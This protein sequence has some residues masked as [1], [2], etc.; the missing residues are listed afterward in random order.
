M[1][2][3][4]DSLIL[5]LI[6]YTLIVPIVRGLSGSG[7][8]DPTAPI[9]ARLEATTAP[10]PRSESL[11]ALEI[12]G[13]SEAGARL[14]IEMTDGDTLAP[15][16]ECFEVVCDEHVC[17]QLTMDTLPC[18]DAAL[19]IRD[20]QGTTLATRT[21]RLEDDRRSE[22]DATFS[23]ASMRVLDLGKVE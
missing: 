1:R 6:A 8:S 3:F 16:G 22:G 23:T 9:D 13:A 7:S 5:V 21:L 17:F 20:D 18:T 11:P 19:R 12:V 15:I 2:R 14:Q 10:A 4:V